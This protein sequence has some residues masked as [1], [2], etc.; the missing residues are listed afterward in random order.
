MKRGRGRN[1]NN[2]GGRRPNNN[3]GGNNS[4]RNME[5]NGPDVKVRGT[6]HQ[7][8]EKYQQLARDANASGD[9]IAHENYL[10]HAEHYHRIILASQPAPQPQREAPVAERQDDDAGNVAVEE[11]AI[12]E[13]AAPE[14][15]SA[16]PVAKSAA[17]AEA[18]AETKAE[19]NED[20][21]P[22]V[23]RPR[24][25]RRARTTVRASG[26]ADETA[27][28]IAPKAATKPTPDAAEAPAEG[29]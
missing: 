24:R 6:A 12:E 21:G 28:E 9:R 7:I 25:G 13:V 8:S 5:S 29:A 10:Q 14:K 3:N 22:R 1:N 27:A 26:E 18:K 20:D 19:A 11:I 23:P 15:R 17:K 2:S 16:K 4:N